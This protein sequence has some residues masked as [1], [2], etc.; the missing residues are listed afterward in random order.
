MAWVSLINFVNLIIFLKNKIFTT[1]K[2][3][4]HYDSMQKINNYQYYEN[5]SSQYSKNISMIL[6]VNKI[7]IKWEYNNFI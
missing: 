6:F 2:T 5:I 1:N 4:K 3:K 7:K